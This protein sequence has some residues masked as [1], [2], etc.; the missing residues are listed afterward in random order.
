MA[1][2]IASFFDRLRNLTVPDGATRDAV[3]SALS[4][5]MQIDIDRAHVR[6]K[7]NTAFL[8]ISPLIKAEVQFRERELLR[9]V[10]ERLGKEIL[11][12]IR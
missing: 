10:A 11:M 8:N 12:A 4:E 5:V 6:I 9:A 3:A 2:H 7:G 1:R